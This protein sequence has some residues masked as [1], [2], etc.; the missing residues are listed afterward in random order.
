MSI[1]RLAR[2]VSLGGELVEL[3]LK[4]Y[5]LLVALASD[6]GRVFTKRELLRDVLRRA[7]NSAV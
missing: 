3:S 2:N 5:E 1:D 4:E 7:A 6:P